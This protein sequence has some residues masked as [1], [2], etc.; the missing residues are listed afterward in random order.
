MDVTA[1]FIKGILMTTSLGKSCAFGLLW[2]F[3]LT[4]IKCVCVCV[5][6]CVFV[7]VCVI[8]PFGFESGMWDLVADCTCVASILILPMH[9]D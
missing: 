8:F 1:V 6:V 2:I 3:S 4:F 9:M 5:C 7:C